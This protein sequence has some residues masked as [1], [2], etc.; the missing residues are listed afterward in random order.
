MRDLVERLEAL[1]P[2][3]SL[4][5]VAQ[6]VETCR[7]DSAD[8]APFVRTNRQSYNRASVAVREHFEVL[9]MTWLPGQASVPHDH[10]GSICAMQV[11]EGEASEGAYRVAAD[12][13]ADLEYETNVPQG[14]VTAGQDAGVHTVRNAST[15]GQVLVTVHVYAPPLRD[16]RRFVPRPLPASERQPATECDTPT[17]VVVGGGFSGSIAAAQILRRAASAGA[18]VRVVVIERR[19]AIGEG[20]AYGTREASHLLNVPAN[21]MSAWPD[22]PD[23]FAHW[24]SQRHG[25]V[26]PSD[27]LPRQW[28][29]EYIRETLLS[30]ARESPPGALS[31]VFDEVR[32][33]A[34]HP[35]EG[36]MVHLAR[37]NSLRARAVVLAIGHRPPS[38][39]IGRKWSGPRARFIADPWRPFAMNAIQPDE[40]VAILGSGLTAVDAVLSL[41]DASHQA[42]ITL[43]SRNGLA[44]QAH[45][46]APSAPVKLEAWAAELLAAREGVRARAMCRGLREKAHDVL[47]QGGDWRSVVDGMRPHTAAL[48]QAMPSAERRRFLSRL[49]PFWEIHRHRMALPVAERFRALMQRRQVQMIAGRVESVQAEN[50]QVRLLVRERATERLIALQAGW[51]VNCTGPMPCNS[52]ESNPVI[53]TLLVDGWL[54]LDELALG[55]E[56]TPDGNALDVHEQEVADLFVVGTLR[57]P[58]LWETTA[59]PE[60][61][62]QAAT[63]AAWAFEIAVPSNRT[64]GLSES[65]SRS[66]RVA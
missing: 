40:P 53:G 54:R 51:V 9:V 57:K 45:A 24:A 66:G 12:G 8:V 2:N 18:N 44:P 48:W 56:T 7:L 6:A 13:Y 59:V 41:A 63:V 21:R 27:F 11:V 52:P 29:G 14:Q 64:R 23:D 36:W 22:K 3:P 32:R 49:R 50:D 16:F 37:G 46:A 47:E 19:G 60:L 5:Q 20:L 30:V 34:R 10:T 55:I 38:D 65:R 17:V 61:R 42:P 58:A 35:V 4:V 1:G 26:M 15:T 28:Y 33:V 31:V 62:S 39:P 43:L 25:G